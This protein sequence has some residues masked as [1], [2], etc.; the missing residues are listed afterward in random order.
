[1]VNFYTATKE[2]WRAYSK[3]W[4]KNNKDSVRRTSEKQKLHKR[5]NPHYLEWYR[6]YRLKNREKIRSRK[7]F[8]NAI[9]YGKI[10]RKPCEVCSSTNAE[11]HHDDYSKPLEVRWFC[12]EHHEQYHHDHPGV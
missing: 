9:K 1:M 7:I 2:E 10:S 12:K 3:E 8:N 11:G 6:Q 5:G 4:R